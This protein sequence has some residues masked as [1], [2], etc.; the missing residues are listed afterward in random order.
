MSITRTIAT[1]TTLVFF[2]GTGCTTQPSITPTSPLPGNTTASPQLEKDTLFMVMGMD[3]AEDGG[4]GQRKVVN[5]EIIETTPERGRENWTI[6]R[7]GKLVRYK[8]SFTPSP[9]G[10]TDIGLLP[11]EVVGA[12][13]PLKLPKTFSD[14][15]YRTE[16][17]QWLLAYKEQ[18]T[19]VVSNEKLQ[20]THGQGIV[21]VPISSIKNVFPQKK[22]APDIMNAWVVVEYRA[23]D[24]DA[25]IAFK[26]SP[27]KDLNLFTGKRS[28]D[29]IY[30]AISWAREMK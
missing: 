12:I 14:V 19:L 20:F 30:S 10:G 27:V 22:L 11:G 24:K 21:E 17:A 23:A 2:F 16:E 29:E 25:I 4:C 8:I 26:Y 5:R 3:R 15:W 1:M 9:R 7:C 13:A 28:D 6:D 18:G